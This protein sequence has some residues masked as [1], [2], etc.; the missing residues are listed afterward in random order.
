MLVEASGAAR[1]CEIAAPAAAA[2]WPLGA[3]MATT[4]VTAPAIIG[5]R[6]LRGIRPPGLLWV[7]VRYAGT[8]SFRQ[9]GPPTRHK[10]VI[11]A[12]TGSD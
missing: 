7:A 10:I 5:Q 8:I 3:A 6:R 2:G 11:R 1:R 9:E 4:A 12:V